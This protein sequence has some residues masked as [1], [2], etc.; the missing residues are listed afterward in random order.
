MQG[1]VPKYRLNVFES[2]H[3]SLSVIGRVNLPVPRC[4]VIGHRQ[5]TKEKSDQS[6]C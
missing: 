3:V 5:A 6:L 1:I 2:H 4:A